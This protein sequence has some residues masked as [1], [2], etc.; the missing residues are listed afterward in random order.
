MSDATI[1][2]SIDSSGMKSGAE[3]GKRALQEL[4]RAA[5]DYSKGGGA[6]LARAASSNSEHAKAVSTSARETVAALKRADAERKQVERGAVSEMK[7]IYADAL[8]AESDLKRQ[9]E[10][11]KRSANASVAKEA[12]ERTRIERAAL[13]A[14]KAIWAEEDRIRK[15]M[16]KPVKGR[17]FASKVQEVGTLNAAL[18]RTIDLLNRQATAESHLANF[19]TKQLA[20]PAPAQPTLAL[21]YYPNAVTYGSGRQN[22]GISPSGVSGPKKWDSN[23]LANPI[24][25]LPYYGEMSGGRLGSSGNAAVGQRTLASRSEAAGSLGGGSFAQWDKAKLGILQYGIAL[26]QAHKDTALFQ[27]GTGALSSSL[28]VLGSAASAIEGPFGHIAYRMHGMASLFDSTNKKLALITFTVTGLIASVAT[29]A[30]QGSKLTEWDNKLRLLG[31]SGDDIKSTREELFKMSQDSRAPMEQTLNT[32]F[33]FSKATEG[34]KIAQGELLDAVK[35]TNLAAAMSGASVATTTGALYQFGQAIS[36]NRFSADEFR[37]VAEGL[38]GIIDAIRKPLGLTVGELKLAG[39]AGKLTADILRKSLVVSL[40]DLQKQFQKTS[41]TLPQAW[42]KVGNAFTMVV[43]KMDQSIGTSKGLAHAL[44][45]LSKNMGVVAGVTLTFVAGLT[46]LVG[47]GLI[48]KAI[49]LITALSSPWLLLAAAITAAVTGLVLFTKGQDGVKE[50]FSGV[51]ENYDKYKKEL[52]D[53]GSKLHGIGKGGHTSGVSS[54]DIARDLTER[55]RIAEMESPLRRK[56]DIDF[57]KEEAKLGYTTS[58]D[59]VKTKNKFTSSE[60][61]LVKQ[62]LEREEYLKIRNAIVSTQGATESYSYSVKALTELKAKGAL[63]EKQYQKQMFEAKD[64]LIAQTGSVASADLAL[65]KYH[66]KVSK[67]VLGLSEFNYELKRLQAT[68]EDAQTSVEKMF[69]GMAYDKESRA[70]RIDVLKSLSSGVELNDTG[71]D[72]GDILKKLRDEKMSAVEAINP[73]TFEEGMMKSFETIKLQGE[74]IFSDLGEQVGSIFGP[75]GTLTTGLADGLTQMIVMGKSGKEVFQELGQTI[76]KELVGALIKAVIQALILKAL[77]AIGG[78]LTGGATSAAAW[79]NPDTASAFS[80]SGAGLLGGAIAMANG[81]VVRKYADGTGKVFGAGG[82]KSDMI[83]AYL[84]NGERVIDA[85]T[86][87][88]HSYL[89]DRLHN[90]QPFGQTGGS[91]PKVTIINQNRGVIVEE[92]MMSRDEII[93]TIKRESDKAVKDKAGAV[94]AGEL[95]NP[96]SRTSKSMQQNYTMTRKRT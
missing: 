24:L 70:K 6:A 56:V 49:G 59:K 18:Q 76:L 77:G 71:V 16:E 45:F 19:K 66:G 43:G 60:A 34:Q 12:A 15:E 64:A 62:A 51:T 40:G 11:L 52:A 82:P 79:V 14:S 88:R 63:T 26:K 37:S 8:K 3:A 42:I 95:S 84:S 94:V 20:L 73:T 22:I 83:P 32:Y 33:R 93:M 38:P 21:P 57:M 53:Y 91:L 85:A 36:S 65:E 31:K 10:T 25:A 96:N 69:A 78:A 7:Q 90:N 75:D 50:M 29:L 58:K 55:L 44:D 17:V 30:T 5:E 9:T 68:S 80:S 74:T 89:L 39:E 47:G 41:E 2:T 4:K 23:V 67:V 72:Q 48:V 27:S 86:N 87:A 92:T 54:S 1:Y 46:V 28:H 61:S 81:G 35:A 13:A